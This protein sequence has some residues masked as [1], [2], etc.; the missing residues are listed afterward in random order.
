MSCNGMSPHIRHPELVSGSVQVVAVLLQIPNQVRDDSLDVGS[1]LGGFFP[2][3]KNPLPEPV[4]GNLF[5]KICR[6][7]DYAQ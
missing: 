6:H 3:T 5:A 2:N 4:E 1:S 7:F